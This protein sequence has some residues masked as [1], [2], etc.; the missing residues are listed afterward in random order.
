MSSK[1]TSLAIKLITVIVTSVSIIFILTFVFNYYSLKETYIVVAR[2]DAKD[3]ARITSEHLGAILGGVEKVS[4]TIAVALEN[5][6]YNQTE[7]VGLLKN[8]V[9]FNSGI[10]GMTVAYEPYAYNPDLSY[11]APYV[12]HDAGDIKVS[13]APHNYYNWM[14]YLNPKTDNRALWS[15]P[16]VDTSTDKIMS[17]YSAPFYRYDQGKKRFQGVV[18]ATISLEWLQ[19]IVSSI[20][21]FKTGYAFLISRD[22][23]FVTVPKNGFT[24]N[25]SIFFVA[26][27]LEDPALEN[28]GKE[29]VQGKEGF[30]QIRD[31][32]NH[33]KS[34]VYYAPLSDSGY[35][36][37][38][39]IPEQELFA[40]LYRLYKQLVIIAAGGLIFLV[41][42]IIVISRKITKPLRLL[43][44]STEAIAQG[45]LNVQLAEPASRDEIGSLTR[46]FQEMQEALRE[47]IANLAATTAAKERIESELK[48]ARSIQMSIL[49]KRFPPL[50][51][52]EYV[53]IAALLEPAREVGGDLYDYFMI[54][55]RHLFLAVGDVS[56]KGVPAA[57]F[58]AVT[59]TL[60]KGLSEVG[61][62]P[63]EVFAKVNRELVQENDS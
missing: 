27:M 15:E 54:D 12:Y 7:I 36:L 32:I 31:F 57:L 51:A 35:S 10:Y 45:N 24:M 22:G 49:P 17:T 44:G 21:V 2:N 23:F 11:F 13:T 30:V 61:L 28:L 25:Y 1:K 50:P 26:T 3:L 59:K 19:K 52:G 42:V 5:Y 8:T 9:A 39:V 58:M 41:G 14:W 20:G 18:A 6:S 38:V 46:S 48:I 62:T 29:M 40:D 34:W 16:Y 55:D 4:Q 37:G 60:L 47:Y 53:E 56:D 33:Q 63:A 43:A